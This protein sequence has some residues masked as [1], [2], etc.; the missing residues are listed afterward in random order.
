VPSDSPWGDGAP[1]FVP[2]DSPPSQSAQRPF[3]W[4]ALGAIGVLGAS[5]LVLGLS[6]GIA[7]RRYVHTEAAFRL[8]LALL[9]VVVG[10][11]LFTWSA[12][13]WMIRRRGLRLRPTLALEAA[14]T[15]R[16]WRPYAAGIGLYALML[17]VLAIFPPPP[18]ET[19]LITEI[20]RNGGIGLV[21]L[22]ATAVF[23]APVLEESL[24]RGL[25]LPA[26]RQR[27][28][29]WPAALAVTA[30]FTVLHV[31]QVGGYLPALAGIFACGL[32]LAW[33]REKSGSLWPSIAFHM[34]FNSTPFLVWLISL[35]FGGLKDGPLGLLI[36][37][38]PLSLCLAAQGA[39]R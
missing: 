8:D 31:A 19:N 3:L 35:P 23:L 4:G 27:F 2:A 12:I 7:L 25:L 28:A 37:L 10:S 17:P 32:A 36:Y 26:L 21:F 6:L 33:L 9:V 30:L 34:G 15:R 1:A 14:P 39:F 29:L 13:F 24:F 5:Q 11:H 22:L 38:K 20:F 18:D 16:L